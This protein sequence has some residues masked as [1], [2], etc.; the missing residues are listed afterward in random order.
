[1]Y[2]GARIWFM[3][4]VNIRILVIKL[5]R[6][7]TQVGRTKT[8]GWVETKRFGYVERKIW[9]PKEGRKLHDFCGF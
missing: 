5:T 7:A 1:M 2:L 4:K 6:A 9:G 3:A 8:F